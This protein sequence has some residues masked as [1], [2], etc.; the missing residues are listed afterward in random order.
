MPKFHRL[1]LEH[2]FRNDGKIT[3]NNKL[4][5]YDISYI[6]NYQNT[7]V[8]FSEILF[9]I[10]MCKPGLIKHPGWWTNLTLH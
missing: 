1:S 3:G 5:D 9:S 2:S 6:W 8:K 10:L 7:F 4:R